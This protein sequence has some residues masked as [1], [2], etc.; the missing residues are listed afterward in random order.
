[1]NITDAASAPQSAA[2]SN[3]R[4][5]EV[6]E[7]Y[8]ALLK[9]ANPIDREAFRAEHADLGPALAE[10]L[11]ALDFLEAAGPS[12]R[13]DGAGG[14]GAGPDWTGGIHAALGDFRILRELGRGGMGIVYEAEQMSLSRRVA[15]KVLPFAATMDPRHL[16][17]FRNEAQAAAQLHHTHIVPVHYVG[18]ERGVHFYAMQCIEG[19]SVASVLGEL[20]GKG[21]MVQPEGIKDPDQPQGDLPASSPPKSTVVALTTDYGSNRREYFRKVAELG[22]QVAEARD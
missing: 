7:Q 14:P 17:R 18:C 16:Q 22:V 5:A 11:D 1:M 15:L 20:R 10:C 19:D 9:S 4:L 3:P 6:V 12:L 2:G 21:Q 13:A 8:R